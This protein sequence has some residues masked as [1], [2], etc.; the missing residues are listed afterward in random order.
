M[1]ILTLLSLAIGAPASSAGALNGGP[2]L[3]SALAQQGSNANLDMSRQ[4]LVG[5]L[6]IGKKRSGQ[7]LVTRHVVSLSVQW[8]QLAEIIRGQHYEAVQS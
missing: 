6:K 5:L 4:A 2:L 3:R 8:C 7:L 1:T